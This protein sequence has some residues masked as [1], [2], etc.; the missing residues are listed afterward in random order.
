MPDNPISCAM[1]AATATAATNNHFNLQFSHC[2]LC[3]V[4]ALIYHLY[5]ML[6]ISQTQTAKTE[7]ERERE[8]G[9]EGKGR[10]EF[11]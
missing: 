3:L 6:F 11:A 9:K 4:V 10:E 8:R 7:S 1:R 2:A 5:D